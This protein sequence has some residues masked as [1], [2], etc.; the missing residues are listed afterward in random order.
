MMNQ[1]ARSNGQPRPN[2]RFRW[3]VYAGLIVALGTL[4]GC[5]AVKQMAG[6]PSARVHGVEMRDVGLTSLTLQFDVEVTNPYSVALPVIGLEYV[7]TSRGSQFLEG[8]IG[9]DVS[10]PA[11]GAEVLP[12]PLKIPFLELY[13][14]I[15]DVKEKGTLPYEADLALK[16]E[17]PLV[18]LVRLPMAR[19]GELALPSLP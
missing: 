17:A 3:L 18:G 1:Q 11:G 15:G 12:M 14:V 2:P 7:L 5:A 13:K 4:S 9:A 8:E 19:E 10:I 16:V 6:Y